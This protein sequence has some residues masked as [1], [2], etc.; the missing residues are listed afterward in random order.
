[1][2]F[3]R[4]RPPSLP[5]HPYSPPTRTHNIFRLPTHPSIILS[6]ISEGSWSSLALQPSTLGWP[7]GQ[8]VA[9]LHQKICPDRQ[10]DSYWEKYKVD[11]QGRC[12]DFLSS[13]FYC[14]EWFKVS[15]GW[16]CLCFRNNRATCTGLWSDIDF[17]CS[18]HH[19][20]TKAQVLEQEYSITSVKWYI[21]EIGYPEYYQFCFPSRLSVFSL[22]SF[23]YRTWQ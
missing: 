12:Q 2:G 9:R 16:Q 3:F 11:L 17:Q 23:I 15:E 1:M 10:T 19:G 20:Q 7:I 21:P 22:P 18:P 6:I 14:K 8:T 5:T 13:R 4:L